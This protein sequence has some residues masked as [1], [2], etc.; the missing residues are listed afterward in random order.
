MRTRAC[1]M[2]PVVATIAAPACAPKPDDASLDRQFAEAERLCL[3]RQYAQAEAVLKDYLL[4][5]PEDAGAHYYL[6]RTYLLLGEE[7]FNAYLRGEISN[8]QAADRQGDVRKLIWKFRPD[9]AEGE[10]QTALRLFIRNGRVPPI[11]RFDPKYF[12]MM[13]SL[14]AARILYFRAFF[15]AAYGAPPESLSGFVTRA[16]EYVETARGVLPE[17]AEVDQIGAA[18]RDFAREL[19]IKP[20]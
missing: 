7:L 8:G 2:V 11:E 5:R 20:A 19:G 12:E 13:C 9:I 4:Q 14:D 1:W 10:F 15:L 16:L 17:A 18:L 3:D 6:G